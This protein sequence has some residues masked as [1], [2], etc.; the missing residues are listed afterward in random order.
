MLCTLEETIKLI[1]E[2]KVLHIAAD[3]S[4]LQQLP[5]GRWMGGTTPYLMSEKGGIQTTEWL[6]VDE[7]GYADEVRIVSYGKYNIFQVVEDCYENGLTILIMP[8]GSGVSIQYSKGAP[9]IEELLMHPIVGWIAGFDLEKGGI[10]RVY[11]GTV[12]ESYTDKAVVMYLKLPEGKTAMINM[13]NIFSDDKSE[14]P[15]CFNAIDYSVKNCKL[16]G[17]EINLAEY[18][19]GNKLDTDMPIL[20]EYNGVYLNSTVKSVENGEVTF[21]APIFRDM[22]YRFAVPVEDYA[23]EF[24]RKISEAGAT[25]PVFSCNCVLNFIKGEL[26]GKEIPPFTGPAAFGEI[27]YHLLN[28]TLVYC[29]II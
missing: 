23:A 28:Q 14:P 4:L 3:D 7:I 5:K 25:N 16:D 29:E 1:N 10:P 12:G 9:E 27:A 24:R 19:E 21:Y 22:D 15:I 8:Y 2:G 11:D 6:L 20:T 13:I 18:I 26:E 17:K